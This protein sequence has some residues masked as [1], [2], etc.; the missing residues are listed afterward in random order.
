MRLATG[1]PTMKLS[2]PSTITF[3]IAIALGLLGL[4]QRLG[5][6]HVSI[7]RLDSFWFVTA[8]FLLLAAGATFK[9]L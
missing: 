3:L 6:V 8:G 1:V 5:V 9:K 7:I 2:A 4:L